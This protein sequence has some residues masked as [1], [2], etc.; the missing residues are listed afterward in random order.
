MKKILVVDNHPLILQFMKKLLEGEG[1][2]VATAKDGLSAIDILTEDTFE[3]IFIDLIMP[4]ISGRQ[5]CHIIRS[6][7]NHKNAYIV[8]LSAIAAEDDVDCLEIG[9]D[10]CIEKGRIDKT[11]LH[12]LDLLHSFESG[13]PRRRS[14]DIIGYNDINKREITRELLHSG[15]HLSSI[16]NNL[17]EGVLEISTDNRIVYANA[18]AFSITGIS[19]EKLLAKKF[20]AL[21][22]K[23]DQD[24]INSLLIVGDAKRKEMIFGNTFLLINGIQITVNILP[25]KRGDCSYI[26][27]ILNDITEQKRMED[28]LRYAQKMEAV[29]ALSGGIAHDFNNILMGIQGNISLILFGIGQED[30]HYGK[31]KNIEQYIENGAKLTRQLLEYARGG[32]YEIKTVCLNDLIKKQNLMFGQ[33]RKGITI[34]E[35][36]E[37]SLWP[38]DVD[39]GQIE[40]VFL[41]LNINACHAMK[42]CGKLFVKT[43]N[44]IL[45]NNYKKPYK[46]N[47]GRY[48]RISVTDNGTG[49]DEETQKRIFD[50]FFT[51]K[52][53][54]E[55]S[56][57]GLASS[58]GIIKNHRGIINVYSVINEGTTFNIYLPSSDKKVIE[59]KD[60]DEE[61]TSATE[62]VL[63]VDDEEMILDVNKEILQ[64]MGYSVL[65]AGSGVEA[66]N[67]MNQS[68]LSTIINDKG[69][70]ND[71]S[72]GIHGDPDLVILD[73]IMP[74]MGGGEV[75][76]KIKDIN[77]NIKV[78]LSSGYSKNGK[79]N[80]ILKRGCDGFIQ[81]P[82]NMKNLSKRIRRVLDA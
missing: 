42:G 78:L 47:P 65:T 30:P 79:V 37:N 60:T 22:Q 31:L 76:D 52:N 13:I 5:L 53:V 43:E 4:N 50:P 25:A 75:F 55:G 45:D 44:I 29:G 39:Q 33:A 68:D 40:Q 38:V 1:H 67:I 46:I 41:N 3:I 82:F 7:P 8:I 6:M 48:V 74:D 17:A 66:L 2:I 35:D 14:R 69:Q 58:Y 49:M 57:L 23:S 51:T 28:Q 19:E 24:K 10:A 59:E 34:K 15:R 77:P 12:I 21:F 64:S 63:L 73:M 71:V 27:A 36:Y 32:K 11:R 18:A 61:I 62:T 72:Y 70:K 9:A 16:L 56:G 54:G 80:E 20:V 81:K 26:I